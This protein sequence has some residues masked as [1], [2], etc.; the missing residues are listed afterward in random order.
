MLLS[1]FRRVSLFLIGVLVILS[2]SSGIEES[3]KFVIGDMVIKPGEVKSGYLPVPEKNGIQTRIPVT[4]VNGSNPGKVLAL[5]AGVHGYEYP[6]ILSLY[7]LKSSID[8]SELSGTLILVHIANLQS[9]QKRIIYYNPNDWKN[10][11]RVFPGDPE[12]TISQR[13][14][15]V[16]KKEVVDRC[17]YL[18]DLHCGDGNEALIPYTYWMISGNK[19][20]DELSKKMALAFGIKYIIIDQSRTKD[21]TDSKYLGNTAVLFKK[22]A[23]TTESGYLGKSD[24]ESI[25]RNTKGILSVMRLFGMIR[26]EPKMV[27]DPIWIDKYEV[28]YSQADGLFYP[29]TEMGY[30]VKEGEIVGYLTD[31][32]GNMIQELRAPFTG[33]LLYIINTP[34][35][36]KGEPLF[37]VGSVLNNHDPT[38][39]RPHANP[40][41]P[42]FKDGK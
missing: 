1:D 6:P 20:L 41:H 12:G 18:I 5:V 30:Y 9:F 22:P 38:T 15:Y 36:N 10:L 4:V 40:P 32:L 33:I 26:G 37:E 17:D 39:I 16:L 42:T 21:A 27:T 29:L 25:V 7:R 3:G 11:N 34:P 2:F 24:E 8:P 31:Y 35:A 13:V 14:A 19:E 28:V 23:I